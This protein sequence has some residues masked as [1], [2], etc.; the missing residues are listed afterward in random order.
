ARMI[1][2]LVS[3]LSNR[4]RNR[5]KSREKRIIFPQINQ[6]FRI[7]KRFDIDMETTLTED[8][9]NLLLFKDFFKRKNHAG[10]LQMNNIRRYDSKCNSKI[11]F[12]DPFLIPIQ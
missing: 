5:M 4:S 10:P 6:V 2:N 3:V 7:Y 1:P 11:L 9:R 12:L 8:D